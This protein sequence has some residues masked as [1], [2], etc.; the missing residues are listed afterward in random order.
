MEQ[1]TT[2]RI[3]SIIKA[4]L[5]KAKGRKT[6]AEYIDAMLNYFEITNIEPSSIRT[7]PGIETI[8]RIESVIKIL[9]NIEK[10]KIDPILRLLNDRV[11]TSDVGEQIVEGVTV[12]QLNQVLAKNEDLEN[13]VKTLKEELSNAHL[14]LL[15]NANSSS[16]SSNSELLEL[17]ESLLNVSNYKSLSNTNDL[18]ISSQTVEAFRKRLAMFK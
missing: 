16:V 17:L 14:N 4:R 12:D 6:H 9:K 13:Q 11:P 1:T 10:T 8:N 18:V 15:S 7:H 5:E 2:I 3:P